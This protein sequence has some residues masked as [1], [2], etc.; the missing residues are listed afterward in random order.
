MFMSDC[1][2]VTSAWSNNRWCH[3]YWGAGFLGPYVCFYY[4][5]VRM[6]MVFD[7]LK[8]PALTVLSP[9]GGGWVRHCLSVTWLL[10]IQWLL[11]LRGVEAWTPAWPP[12]QDTFHLVSLCS[13]HWG[14]EKKRGAQRSKESIPETSSML[15]V[16][17]RRSQVRMEGY[18]RC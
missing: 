2:F 13:T 4:K 5:R 6:V 12:S 14:A 8:P 1:V 16:Q 7:S 9:Q 3:A 15:S 11:N 18:V 10:R 17:G